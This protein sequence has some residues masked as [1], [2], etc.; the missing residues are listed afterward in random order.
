MRLRERFQTL[1]AA[2]LLAGLGGAAGGA[3]GAPAKTAKAWTDRFHTS[4]CVWSSTGKN[5]FFILEPGDQA[6]FEGREGK[7]AVTLVVTVLD[8]TK[9]IGG[10]ETRIVEERETHDGKLVEVSRNYFAVCGPTNDVFYFGEDV[11]LYK[12]G[13]VE[14]HGGSWV[15]EKDGARPGLFMPSR[16]LLGSRFYQEMAPG[17]A[18]D[19]V[20]IESDNETLKTP[21][22]EFRECLRTKETTPLEPDANDYKIYA[23]GVGMISD[24]GLLISKHANIGA[25]GR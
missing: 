6:T 16:T 12:N 18:M 5:D 4:A 24:G 17:V 23:R 13:K 8:E 3:P 25:G 14:S 20:E 22:G 7:R 11:D 10:V 15:A 9:R 2:G 19:R 21:A 1:L